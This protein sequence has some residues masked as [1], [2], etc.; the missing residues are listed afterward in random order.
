M[1]QQ[2]ALENAVRAVV[3]G[4]PAQA[5]GYAIIPYDGEVTVE[6][7]PDAESMR[8]DLAAL[9]VRGSKWQYPLSWESVLF[10]EPDR[11]FRFI[12]TIELADAD[13]EV[14]K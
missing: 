13:F 10:F 14:T 3:I 6:T 2:S 1:A 4:D 9:F 12:V 8:R 11:P 7:F 5:Y